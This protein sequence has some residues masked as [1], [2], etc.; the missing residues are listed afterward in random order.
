MSYLGP[1]LILT[2][3]IISTDKPKDFNIKHY[4]KILNKM[5][6]GEAYNPIILRRISGRLNLIT[7]WYRLHAARELKWI[8]VKAYVEDVEWEF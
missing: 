1:Y 5:K 2:D 4:D 8:S 6:A 7:G 3:V